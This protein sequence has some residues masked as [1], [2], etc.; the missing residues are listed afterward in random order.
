MLESMRAEVSES[1]ELYPPESGFDFGFG[2]K[3]GAVAEAG[4]AL[5][6]LRRIA[7]QVRKG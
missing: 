1:Q 3:D 5:P 6:T 7:A 2:R 4:S